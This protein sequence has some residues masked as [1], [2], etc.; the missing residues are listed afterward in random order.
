MIA[1]RPL[2]SK[3]FATKNF[4]CLSAAHLADAARILRDALAHMPSAY[5]GPG[6]AEAEV[7]T[8][9]DHP[10]RFALAALDGDRLL[11]WIGGIRENYSHAYELHPLVVDPPRQRR[12]IGSALVAALEAKSRAEGAI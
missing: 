12:G 6:A 4:E 8:F 2:L 7:R 11:G 10:S 5:S 1:Q 9:L 3:C